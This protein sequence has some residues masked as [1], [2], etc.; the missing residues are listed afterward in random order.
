MP[1]EEVDVPPAPAS[2][3][4]LQ[5]MAAD[6]SPAPSK[7]D[8]QNEQ[9]SL[10]AADDERCRNSGLIILLNGSLKVSIDK[11]FHGP[12]LQRFVQLFSSKSPSTC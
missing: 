10:F 8:A 9:V 2:F 5:V 12:T 4:P 11:E 6:P 1:E 7:R 3:I